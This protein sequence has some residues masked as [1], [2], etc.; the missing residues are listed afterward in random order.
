MKAKMTKSVAKFSTRLITITPVGDHMDS[1]SKINYYHEVSKQ[2]AG[3]AIEAALRC[4]IELFKAKLEHVGTFEQWIEE[5]CE[6]GRAM[7]YRYLQ[8]VQKAVG[9]DDLP[10][11]ADGSE[12][13]RTSAI[14]EILADSDSKTVTEIFCEYGCLKKTA[15]NL[16]GKRE[17]AGRKPKDDQDLA[18]A[19]EKISMSAELNKVALDG[20]IT[21]LYRVGVAEGG[22]GSLGTDAL[23]VVVTALKD[24]VRKAEEILKSRETR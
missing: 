22:F 1:S 5:N 16:G 17:G 6:F 20:I 18:D 23:K 11:L 14:A 24:T 4:G 10:K 8:L 12:K 15:S 2:G 3:L 9:A 7:A 13:Q 21:N 19:A